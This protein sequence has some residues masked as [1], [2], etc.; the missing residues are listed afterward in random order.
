MSDGMLEQKRIGEAMTT[1]KAA[2]R[3]LPVEH[4]RCLPLHSTITRQT[5]A[6]SWP[7]WN[8]GKKRNEGKS[9]TGCTGCKVDAAHAKGAVPIDAPAASMPTIHASAGTS[10]RTMSHHRPRDITAKIVPGL[11]IRS[12]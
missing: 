12:L 10:K 8:D 9:G 6:A 7:L 2:R 3:R 1:S 5:C 11:R 4:F